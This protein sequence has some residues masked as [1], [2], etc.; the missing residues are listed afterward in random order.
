[1]S[2]D[3]EALEATLG[4]QFKNREMLVRALTHSSRVHEQNIENPDSAVGPEA[5]NEQLE[6]LGDAVLGFL[7]SEALVRRFPSHPEGRLS[8]VKARLVGA[9]HLCDVAQKLELGQHLILGRGEEMSG[10]RAKKTLLE[11]CLEALIAALFLDGGI[12]VVRAFVNRYVMGD[13]ERD[14]H[15][16]APERRDNFKGVLQE[17]AR[18]RKLPPP[19]YIMVKERGPEHSKMFTIEVR[20]GPDWVSQAEGPSKKSAAQNAAREVLARIM[21]QNP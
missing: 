6:F 4:H 14:T 13:G 3:L 17:L 8:E 16:L 1:M 12:E 20:L 11:G 21:E 7:I 10:G 19:R 5:D 18:D 2:V 9:A 15:Y